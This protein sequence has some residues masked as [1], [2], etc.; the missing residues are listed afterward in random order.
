[1]EN[2]NA[3]LKMVVPTDWLFSVMPL[4]ASTH[5]DD[6]DYL[7]WFLIITCGILFLLVVVPLTLIV[8]R[9]RRKTVNQ[10]AVA[11]TDHNFWLESIWTFL[12][13]IYLAILFAWGFW[14]YLDMYVA[15]HDSKELRVIGQKWQWSV[16]YPLE[17]IS[18]A[19]AGAQIAV[20]VDTPIK[21]IMA[22]QDVIHSFFIPN[23]RVKQDVVPGRYSTLWFTATRTGEYPVLCAEYCGDLHSQMLAKVVVLTQSEYQ[24]WVNKMKAQDQD[25]PL[26][27]LGKK[28]YDK[29]GC[30]ACHSIDGS[31]R[32]APSFLGIYGKDETLSDGSVV[33]ID[34]DFIRNKIRTPTFK[35]PKAGFAP[36][37]PTFEGRVSERDISGLIAFIKSL[38]KP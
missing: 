12:P 34:D 29:L 37:M 3:L 23:L 26:P 13:F 24:D 30:M 11:Q 35:P 32:L 7:F 8:V 2:L 36:I 25:I 20:P 16:D 6:I 31:P 5:A 15:P 17:E 38:S 28:L 4:G 21:L 1:M 9:Y 19:G 27:E 10:R 22:S 18:V 33:K 14:Q